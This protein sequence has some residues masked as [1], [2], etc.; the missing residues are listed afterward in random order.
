MGLAL[1]KFTGLSQ[2][3]E[4]IALPYNVFLCLLGLLGIVVVSH[5]SEEKFSHSLF[6]LASQ[7]LQWFLIM[8]CLVSITF[9]FQGK[10]AVIWTLIAIATGSSAYG[11]QIFKN[12]K[13]V[14]D[15]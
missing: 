3:D 13:C 5:Y 8:L 9:L 7:S 4:Y 2:N 11:L 6:K 15:A 12:S 14:N 10:E 1:F